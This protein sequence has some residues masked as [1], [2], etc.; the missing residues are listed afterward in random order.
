VPIKKISEYAEIDASAVTN[1][2][3][4][5]FQIGNTFRKVKARFLINAPVIIDEDTAILANTRVGAD[6]EA[7]SFTF[8]LTSSQIQGDRLTV[9]DPTG[10]WS[11]NPLTIAGDIEDASGNELPDGILCVW[12]LEMNFLCRTDGIWTLEA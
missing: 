1:A 3:W 10:F 11:E 7:G 12:P 4:G 9:Y 5:L 6:T 2:D 8:T